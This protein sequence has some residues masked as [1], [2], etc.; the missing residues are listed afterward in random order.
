[1]WR[2]GRPQTP[3]TETRR[4]SSSSPIS[5][6]CSA[7]CAKCA[8]SAKHSFKEDLTFTVRCDAATAKLLQPMQPYFQQMAHATA[9]DWA[10]TAE[11]QGVP[12]AHH[13][14]QQGT[15]EVHVD[16]SRFIDVGAETQAARERSRKLSPSK[17]SRSTASSPT[18]LRRQSAGRSRPA[19]ARQARRTP[20]PTASVE[21]ALKKLV[22]SVPAF[23]SRVRRVVMVN[24]SIAARRARRKLQHAAFVP[25]AAASYNGSV[26]PD[27]HGLA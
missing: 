9:T 21:A 4:S 2:R 23:S 16:V 24:S 3:R 14:G 8:Q 27:D 1:M 5:R 12:I 7:P 10:R 13:S 17:S 19:A 26:E 20:R 15:I 25:F 6:L 22:S 18:R 11:P